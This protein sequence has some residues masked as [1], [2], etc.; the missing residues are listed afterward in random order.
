[1]EQKA[2]DTCPIKGNAPV[3]GE[4]R[5]KNFVCAVNGKI[6]KKTHV[7]TWEW[8]TNKFSVKKK[9]TKEWRDKSFIS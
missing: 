2:T 9:V 7:R 1:M 8:R 6:G 3:L 4:K 5:K